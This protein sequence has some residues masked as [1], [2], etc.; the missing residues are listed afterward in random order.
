MFGIGPSEMLFLLAIIGVP[1]GLLLMVLIF[2]VRRGGP[3][4]RDD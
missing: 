3:K 4:S 2:A 1:G